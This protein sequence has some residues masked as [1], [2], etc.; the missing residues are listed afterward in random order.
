MANQG[1]AQR[2]PNATKPQTAASRKP[3]PASIPDYVV[4]AATPAGQKE[5]P[6]VQAITRR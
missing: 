1:T 2:P 5:V 4:K 3:L 6:Q